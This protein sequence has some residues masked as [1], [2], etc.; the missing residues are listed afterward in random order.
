VKRHRWEPASEK[1]SRHFGRCV[2]CRLIR[3]RAPGSH[4]THYA[5]M[6]RGRLVPVDF[7]GGT[8]PCVPEEPT[9]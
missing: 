4:T 3:Q 9:P 7:V 5:R 1:P 8:P 6:E 2:D